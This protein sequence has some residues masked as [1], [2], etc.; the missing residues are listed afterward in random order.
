MDNRAAMVRVISSPG[1]PSSHVENRVGEPAANPY[2][3]L[4]AQAASGLDGIRHKIDPGPISDNPYAEETAA[5][6]PQSLGAA[7]EALSADQFFRTAFGSRFIDYLVTMK[8]SEW[9][10]YSAWLEANPDETGYVNGV[11]DW[12]QREYFE[13]F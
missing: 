6:L 10:R 3:Y 2:L 5:Q 9:A 1:D 11:T 4:A 13:L 7:L 12:E 8:G